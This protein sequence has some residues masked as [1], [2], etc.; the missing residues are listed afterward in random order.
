MSLE[1][2][3]AASVSSLVREQSSANNQEKYWECECGAHNP[4]GT[5]K[6]WGRFREHCPQNHKHK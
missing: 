3:S 5:K 2:V 1:G 4:V 6:C